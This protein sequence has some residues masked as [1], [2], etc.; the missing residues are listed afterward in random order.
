MCP[1]CKRGWTPDISLLSI[2]RS[3]AL[4]FR[5]FLPTTNALNLWRLVLCAARSQT[6]YNERAKKERNSFADNRRFYLCFSVSG[7]SMFANRRKRGDCVTFAALN[8]PD[9]RLPSVENSVSARRWRHVALQL[10]YHS[11]LPRFPSA[12]LYRF[13]FLLS[14]NDFVIPKFNVG[15]GERGKG[16]TSPSFFRLS[17][18]LAATLSFSQFLRRVFSA[19]SLLSRILSRSRRRRVVVS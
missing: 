9:E 3:A 16:N 4:W 11:F 19:L 13:S 8:F 12:K 5:H 6:R 7:P 14:F 1:I 15:N 2:T 17:F 18:P 10:N